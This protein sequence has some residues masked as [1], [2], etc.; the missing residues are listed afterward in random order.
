MI[1]LN[2]RDR[3]FRFFIY[4]SIVFITLFLITTFANINSNK[5]ERDVTPSSII[6]NNKNTQINVE[7][8]RYKNDRINKIITDNIYN[9]VKVFKENKENKVLNITYDIYNFDN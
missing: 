1:L 7:Y 9:Y 4:I 8:P 3:L 6:F 2:Y 5:I